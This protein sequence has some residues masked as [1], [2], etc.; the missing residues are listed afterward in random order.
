MR[1]TEQAQGLRLMKFEVVCQQDVGPVRHAA[2]S[3]SRHM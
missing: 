2:F 1:R 3:E